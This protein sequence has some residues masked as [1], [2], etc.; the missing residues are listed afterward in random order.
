[1]NAR[2]ARRPS[3]QESGRKAPQ[4]QADGGHPGDAQ[5]KPRPRLQPDGARL[6]PGRRGRRGARRGDARGQ[7]L[8]GGHG[9]GLRREADR[10]GCEVSPPLR[11]TRLQG[12]VGERGLLERRRRPEGHKGAQEPLPLARGG[13]GRL[14][15]RVHLPRTLRGRGRRQRQQRKDPPAPGQGCA[16]I[17]QRR[18]RHRLPERDDGRAGT[19]DTQGARRLELRREARDGLLGE[20]RLLLLRA[21][22][23]GRG[24]CAGVRRQEGATR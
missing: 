1:M 4:A 19:R 23:G 21:V 6:R 7:P 10:R 24:V 17:R 14:P 13:G 2:G 16:A 5:G 15:M 18:R 12:R 8:L 3:E 11:D 20:V 9:L 22:P